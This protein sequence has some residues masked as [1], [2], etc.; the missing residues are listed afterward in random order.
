MRSFK[1][2]LST[3]NVNLTYIIL[4]TAGQSNFERSSFAVLAERH[5][6]RLTFPTLTAFAFVIVHGTLK[7]IPNGQR[8]R[9][10]RSQFGAVIALLTE[11]LDEGACSVHFLG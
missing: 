10:C 1:M 7:I 9:L 6:T 5:D 2:M 8:V 3:S 11:N 4:L